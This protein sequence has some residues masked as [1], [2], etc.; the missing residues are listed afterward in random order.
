MSRFDAAIIDLDGTL[1]DTLG[2]FE[3]ALNLTFVDLG[4]PMASRHAVSLAIGKG[5]EHLIRSLLGPA[6]QHLYIRAWDTTRRTTRTSTASTRTC[7]RAWSK[8]WID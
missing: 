8:A 1:V 6:K 4:L 5:S 7:L 3:V 2:D